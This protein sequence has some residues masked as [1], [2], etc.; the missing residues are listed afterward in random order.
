MEYPI[1]SCLIIKP[2]T[3]RELLDYVDST[4]QKIASALYFYQRFGYIVGRQDWSLPRS[5]KRYKLTTKGR[6]KLKSMA[7]S[8]RD[9]PEQ[10]GKPKID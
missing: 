5:P 1:F 2:L 9:H 10:W 8:K 6:T 3:C 4:H 7:E